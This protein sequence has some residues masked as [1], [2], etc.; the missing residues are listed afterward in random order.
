MSTI[1]ILLNTKKQGRVTN[2]KKSAK[3][4]FLKYNEAEEEERHQKGVQLRKR[5]RKEKETYKQYKMDMAQIPRRVYD[6]LLDPSNRVGLNIL[7]RQDIVFRVILSNFFEVVSAS[8]DNNINPQQRDING[9]LTALV[10]GNASFDEI[11]GIP[12]AT[13]Y[14]HALG[15]LPALRPFLDPPTVSDHSS[16]SDRSK[17]DDDKKDGDDNNGNDDEKRGGDSNITTRRKRQKTT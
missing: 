10:D 7:A 4:Y 16:D 3:V 14:L 2:S 15:G 9:I 13:G 1:S 12:N 17:G 6:V 8:E 11:I 5:L